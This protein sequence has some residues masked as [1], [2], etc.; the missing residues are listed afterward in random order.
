MKVSRGAHIVLPMDFWPGE[1]SL[2]IPKTDDGRVIF[3]IPWRGYVL[4]GTTD[5]PDELHENPQIQ[6]DEKAYLLSYFNRYSV[7]KASLGDI[8]SD[9]VGQRP[10]LQSAEV[11]DTKS[12]VRDHEVE[13]DASSHLVSILGGKWTTYRVMAEDTMQ[14][15]EKE[16]LGR[17]P[18]ACTTKDHILFGGESNAFAPFVQACQEAS[19]LDDVIQHLW[20]TYGSNALKVLQFGTE[21]FHADFPYLVGEIDYMKKHEMATSWADVLERRWGI[22]LQDLA[23]A[24]QLKGIKKEAFAS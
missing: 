18:Q 21:R 4:V 19:L 12:L 2:L 3:V 1:T 16:V 10:L 5:D 14:V 6:A 7:K 23:K 17:D 20:S 11:G 8:T 22:A 9:F 24:D 13:L 15:V